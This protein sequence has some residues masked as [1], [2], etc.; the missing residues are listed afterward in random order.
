LAAATAAKFSATALAGIRSERKAMASSAKGD[1]SDQGEHLPQV[2]VG[3][4]RE[5]G[6]LG[7]D[8]ADPEHC[9]V[10]GRRAADCPDRALPGGQ[11]GLGGREDSDQ[12]GAAGPVVRPGRRYRV[13]DPRQR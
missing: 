5:V 3:V 1:Q 9:R 4:R 11:A 7:A 6:D 2:A 12:G 8:A 13:V 10:V